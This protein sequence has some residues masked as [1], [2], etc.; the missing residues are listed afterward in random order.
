MGNWKY[1]G[2]TRDGQRVSGTV[3]AKDKKEIKKILRNKGVLP[4]KLTPPSILEFDI[5]EYL[6]QQGFIKPFGDQDLLLFTKQF[7]IM[8]DAGVPVLQGLEVLQKQEKNPALRVALKHIA[9]D[10]REGETLS[11]SIGKQKGFSRLYVNLIKAGEA[12]GVLDTILN[13]LSEHIERQQQI[14]GQI[15]KAM[16]YPIMIMI[17]GLGVV[18]GLMV[19]V[20]PQFVSLLKDS[21]QEI[22]AITQFVID[23][24]D[25]V[26]K[27][28]LYAI[29][30][31]IISFIFFKIWSQGE[32]KKTF[33]TFLIKLPIIGG[34]VIKGSL[35]SFARTLSTMLSSGVSLVEA[36][37]ICIETIE[38]KVIVTDLMMVRRKVTTGK[39][40]TEPLRSISY[41]P[42]MVTQMVNIGEQTGRIDHML[43]KCANI[44]EGELSRLIDTM[45]G[46][47]QPLAI[48]FLGG[49]V[50]I[51]MLAMYMP[52]F[53]SAGGAG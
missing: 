41:F 39:T 53:Q 1:E 35:A 34:I 32:G 20:V 12:G 52:I 22:P 46:M 26:K 4:K 37:D 8:I 11:D 49:L 5:S 16:T 38:N 28:S 45:T 19:F 18:W 30:G 33:D 36:M 7:Y 44:F 48:I 40:L 10:V 29:P 17:I 13:K 25:W 42:D 6:V 9:S 24:S 3:A 51:V 47:L 23:T 14:K 50:A 27:Y 31:L 43:E 2:I 15:K 21:G